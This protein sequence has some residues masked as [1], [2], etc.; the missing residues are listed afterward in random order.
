MFVL[1]VSR[2][3]LSDWFEQRRRKWQ[4]RVG[5]AVSLPYKKSLSA[6]WTR[7]QNWCIIASLSTPNVD[8]FR[9]SIEIYCSFLDFYLSFYKHETVKSYLK[10]INTFAV[11]ETG[12]PIHSHLNKLWIRRTYVAAAKQAATPTACKRLPLTVEILTKLR[13]F[14]NFENN[15]GRALWAIL[16]VGVLSLAR[17]GELV[18]GQSSKLKVTLGAVD[19]KGNRGAI[20]PIYRH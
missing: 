8:M 17:I 9:P 12:H 20:T 7:W 3:E 10:R 1:G 2:K 6:A 5:T 4:V 11:Q 14:V 13:P 15:D 18:P 19:I 16:C